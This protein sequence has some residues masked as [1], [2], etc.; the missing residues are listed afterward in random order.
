[1]ITVTKKKILFSLIVFFMLM[2]V[3]QAVVPPIPYPISNPLLAEEAWN[4]NDTAVS[5]IGKTDGT[6]GSGC[7]YNADTPLSSGKSLY[8]D[9]STDGYFDT[10]WQNLSLLDAYSFSYWWKNTIDNGA[11]IYGSQ[12]TGSYAFLGW[13]DSGLLYN[14]NFDA[15]NA[16]YTTVPT[17]NFGSDT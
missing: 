17:S 12:V 8:C 5:L 11:Y 14:Y 2:G 4:F 7:S 6:L 3:T 10:N 13:A 16:F 15:S 9:G 1:M